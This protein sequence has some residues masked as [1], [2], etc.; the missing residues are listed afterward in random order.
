LLT[1]A[2]E[3]QILELADTQLTLNRIPFDFCINL[4]RLNLSANK[5][6]KADM[7]RVKT[8]GFS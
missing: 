1:E 2:K 5:F 8:T 6:P 7:V 3:L 4:R